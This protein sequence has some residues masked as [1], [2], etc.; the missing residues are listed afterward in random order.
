MKHSHGRGEAVSEVNHPTGNSPLKEA[1]SEE[2]GEWHQRFSDREIWFAPKLSTAHSSAKNGQYATKVLR[3]WMF[4][5]SRSFYSGRSV[6]GPC[7]PCHPRWAAFT[8]SPCCQTQCRLDP[9][10]KQFA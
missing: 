8:G 7:H 10:A 9:L 3:E 2:N 6:G 5:T 1:R 4:S